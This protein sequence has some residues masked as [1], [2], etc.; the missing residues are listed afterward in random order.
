MEVP[1]TTGVPAALIRLA[2]DTLVTEEPASL[3][4]L[5]A[6]R[7]LVASGRAVVQ[8]LEQDGLLLSTD[9]DGRHKAVVRVINRQRVRWWHLPAD[10][11]RGASTFYTLLAKHPG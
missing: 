7:S 5:Q 1:H 11:F 4:F 3:V 2:L 8:M 9:S 6:V 10:M